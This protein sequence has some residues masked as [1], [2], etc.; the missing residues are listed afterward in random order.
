[1]A[2]AHGDVTVQIMAHYFLGAAYHASGAYRQARDHLDQNVARLAGERAQE[3][4]GL[5]GLASVFSRT[6][7]VWSLAE[8]GEFTAGLARGAEG[9]RLA[10]A[11]DHPYSLLHAQFGLG[12]LLLRQGDLAGAISW[13]DGD[14]IEALKDELIYAQHV[15]VDEDGRVLVWT[16]HTGGHCQVN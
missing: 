15:A 3:R 4:F 10:E 9:V 1:M 16:G 14:A 13:L 2:R 11:V 8:L 7:L 12:V 5:A 6:F